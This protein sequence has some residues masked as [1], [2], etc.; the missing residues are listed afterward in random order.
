MPEEHATILMPLLFF[1]AGRW[2]THVIPERLVC[3]QGLRR[4]FLCPEGSGHRGIAV[5]RLRPR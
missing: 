3:T 1:A 5:V 2:T 4:G